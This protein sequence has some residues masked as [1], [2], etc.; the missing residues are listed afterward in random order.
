MLR[1]RVPNVRLGIH[2]RRR[3]APVATG[4][5]ALDDLL[6][7]GL[8]GGDLTELVGE[9]P[10]SGSAQVLHAFIR[11]TGRDGRFMAL[12]DGAEIGR[13]HV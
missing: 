8:A 12:V 5:G 11:N 4:V 9:G 7:G 13:A 6:G 3:A 2:G 1:A 10:G